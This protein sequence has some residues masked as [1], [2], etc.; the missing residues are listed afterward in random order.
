MLKTSRRTQ[1][2]IIQSQYKKINKK[3]QIGQQLISN[4]P[5]PRTHSPM[6]RESSGVTPM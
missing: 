3:F 1:L 6:N 4:P 2:K 5:K